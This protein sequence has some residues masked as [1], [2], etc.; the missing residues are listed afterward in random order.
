MS[1]SDTMSEASMSEAS[2]SEASMSEA[3]MSNV[4]DID[5]AAEF[6]L[7]AEFEE[8]VNQITSIQASYETSIEKLQW[9]QNQ[10]HY[11]DPLDAILEELHVEALKEIEETGDC[12]FGAKL[13]AR[14]SQK[15]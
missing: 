4:S 12:S 6:D 3:S 11:V 5:F 7:V 13:L 1:E 8:A 10:I 2:M 9:I 14:L 15:I